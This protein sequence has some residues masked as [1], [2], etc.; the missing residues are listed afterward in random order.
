MMFNFLFVNRLLMSCI[1]QESFNH[2]QVSAKPF[3]R[4]KTLGV[5]VW[6]VEF[7]K[8][9]SNFNFFCFS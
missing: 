3:L 1:Y 8:D 2:I 9:F 7:S 5:L 6:S 4:I